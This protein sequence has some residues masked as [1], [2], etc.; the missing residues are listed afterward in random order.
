MKIDEVLHTGKR[1]LRTRPRTLL[2]GP[3]GA[4]LWADCLEPVPG[5]SGSIDFIHK[6]NIPDVFTVKCDRVPLFEPARIDWFP[7]HLKMEYADCFVHLTEVKYI[8]WDDCAVSRQSWENVGNRDIRIRLTAAGY[9]KLRGDGRYGGTI[10]SESHHYRVR[11]VLS[12]GAVWKDGIVCLKPG[13]KI[14]FTV[15][16]AFGIDGSDSDAALESRASRAAG[17]RGDGARLA[18]AHAQEYQH[19]YDRMPAFRSSETLLDKTWAYRWFILRHNLAA[20][21]YGN[22]PYPLF[23]EGRSHKM[24][25]QPYHPEGW[26][27]SKLIPLSVPMHLLDAR[28]HYDTAACMGS[29]RNVRRSQD[30]DGIYHCMYV[31]RPGTYY[32]NFIPWAGYQLYLISRDPAILRDILPSFKRQ[33]RG[34]GK[35]FGNADDSLLIERDHKRTGK[36]YQ[37]SYWYFTGFPDDCRDKSRITPLKRVDRNV[38]YYRNALGVAELCRMAGDPEEKAFRQLAR[39]I[40]TD[41]LGKMWDRETRF[42]YDLKHDDDQKAFVQNI[43]GFYPYW[44]DMTGPEYARGMGRLMTPEF[45]TGCPFPSVSADCPVFSAQGGWKGRFIKGRNGCVWDGP[46]WPYTNSIVLDA[47]AVQSKANGHIYDSDFGRFFR[48]Y[49]LLH[50][51]RRDLQRPCLVEHYDSLTGEPLSDEADY[52]HSYYIDLLIRHIAGLEV[53]MDGLMLDPVDIGLAYFDLDH[54]RAA[55]R[56][57][58]VAYHAPGCQTG[59]TDIPEGYSLYVDGKPVRHSEKLEK[60]EYPFLSV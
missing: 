58:R 9:F 57:I 2:L 47:L 13:E 25:K 40:R 50:F 23:Y 38:Y 49:S 12:A 44:A 32:A 17:G 37:P 43:V 27:F 20:P 39:R 14:R 6:M 30:G 55:G 10:E 24:R 35:V 52:N 22:L 21:G 45:D 1:S 59:G 11:A 31:D 26:E 41:I 3:S 51:E 56:D 5:F 15:A 7:S 18:A 54:V 33:V 36:E 48:Q 8:T 53:E 16:A 42:F 19:W 4:R 29:L 60:M 34:W 46:T 28:W